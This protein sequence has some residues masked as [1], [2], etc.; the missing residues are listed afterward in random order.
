[1]KYISFFSAG[2]R[3]QKELLGGKG[4]NLAE[5]TRIGLPVPPGF[6]VTTKACLA[7]TEKGMTGDMKREIRLAVQKLEEQSG[8][9]FGDPTNPLLVSVRSGAAASMPG[10]MD[11]ILNLG[12]NQKTVEGLADLTSNRWFAYDAFRRF[13]MMFV[14]IVYKIDRQKFEHILEDIKKKEKVEL[15]TD[16]SAAGMQQIASLSVELFSKEAGVFPDDPHKQLIAAV[17]AVF[18]SWN[19]PRAV[20][21][22]NIHKIPHTMGTAVNIQSMV[23]GNM[24]QDSGTGVVFTRNPTNGKKELYGEYLINAQGEDVVS[25]SRT[26]LGI[27]DLKKREPKIYRQLN[28]I[29]TNLENHY[30]DLMDIE[31]TVENKKLYMLQCRVGKRTAEAAVR[32]AVEMVREKRIDKNEALLRVDPQQASVLLH[33]SFKKVDQKPL[34]R[35]LPASPG[36]AT[37]AVIFSPDEAAEVSKKKEVILVRNETTPDDIHGMV[38]AKGV[39]TARGGMTSHAAVVARGMGKPCVVGCNQLTINPEKGTMKLNGRTL[40]KG[41]PIS[42]DGTTGEIYSGSLEVQEAQLYPQLKTLLGWADKIRS[43]KI[44]ANAD[45]PE[46]A[47]R[48]R[49]FGAQ[50]IGLC[51]TEHM[52]MGKDRLPWVQRM[53]MADERSDREQALFKIESMQV[54]DFEGIFTAMNGL[55]VTIRLLDPPLHEFLPNYEQQVIKVHDMEKSGSSSYA[56]ERNILSRIE[57]L[58]EAN[59][60]IGLRGVRLGLLYPEIYEMQVRA[61]FTAACRIS[62]NGKKVLPEIMI[63]LVG[64][65]E[66]LHRCRE[67]LEKTA[68]EVLKKENKRI[69]YLFGTMIELP[70]AALTADQ[71]AEYAEFFSFGTNDLTQMVFGYSRDDV[72]GKILPKYLEQ[73]ILKENPFEVLDQKGVGKL[74]EI[75][76]ESG[77]KKRPDLKLGICGEHG[78]D[79]SSI[80]FCHGLGMNYVS[81]SPFRVPVAR[82]AAA[83]AALSSQ[84]PE[85]SQD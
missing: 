40:K 63:P 58:R 19:N 71:I 50:G 74:M 73:R 49:N 57:S 25:G 60:M 64:T 84:K 85:S 14:N 79:P 55:P 47:E 56:K 27:N 21:Y 65:A 16:I 18:Q 23:F 45:T 78:G 51:R 29:C 83:Q 69:N 54:E 43:L 66:E 62:K 52:F 35:G 11:T 70:R 75:A 22:R 1:M 38:A 80:A 30:R 81:C 36:A 39:L 17:E 9:R 10:M 77:K 3:E 2:S 46:D 61:I 31:F 82:L 15:D 24:G 6:T 4:A 42:L 20:T 68:K 59:P 67:M 32:V 13:V 44:R 8:K 34:G 7:Y 41:D 12:L 37:G 72:E 48:A 76:V 28:K 5:M 33:G 53:I 26:P